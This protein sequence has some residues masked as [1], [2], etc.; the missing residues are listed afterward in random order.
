M[1]NKYLR[2]SRSRIAELCLK[3][4]D[5]PNL[6]P[7]LSTTEFCNFV[8]DE[9]F[10]SQ[11]YLDYDILEVEYHIQLE[12]GGSADNDDE[13]SSYHIITLYDREES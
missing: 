11:S 2:Y 6:M 1:P 10:V 7:Y 5:M 12:R 4:K 3:Y 8:K 9:D 13:S